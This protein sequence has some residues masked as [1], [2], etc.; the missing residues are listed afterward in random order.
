MPQSHA[1]VALD[2]GF[3]RYDD[4]HVVSYAG[5]A[6]A[7]IFLATPAEAFG[8]GPQTHAFVARDTGFRRY[9]EVSVVEYGMIIPNPSAGLSGRLPGGALHWPAPALQAMHVIAVA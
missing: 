6:R 1:F 4:V 7:A 8:L 5:H 3:R 9:D 2:T